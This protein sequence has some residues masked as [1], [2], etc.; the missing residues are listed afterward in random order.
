M[1]AIIDALNWPELADLSFYVEELDAF[2]NS[3]VYLA[4]Q[5]AAREYLCSLNLVIRNQEIPEHVRTMTVGKI[6]GAEAVLDLLRVLRVNNLRQPVHADDPEEQE[7]L[8]AEIAATE[9]H[10]ERVVRS[11]LEDET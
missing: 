9:Q 5:K 3:R 11:L 8:S 7:Q 1:K 4:V 10:T 2:Q 6:C